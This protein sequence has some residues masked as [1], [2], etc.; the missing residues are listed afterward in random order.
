MS[1]T[2]ALRRTAHHAPILLSPVSSTR[3]GRKRVITTGKECGAS[4]TRLFRFLR[5]LHAFGA[6]RAFR[7]LRARHMLSAIGFLHACAVVV[8]TLAK[9]FVEFLR[10]YLWRF[11]LSTQFVANT[12]S[13]TNHRP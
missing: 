1:G 6:L 3:V 11:C 5:P 13:F 8:I 9:V 7:P 10:T 12:I 4:P 2:K